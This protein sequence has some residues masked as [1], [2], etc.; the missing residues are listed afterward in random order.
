VRHI[1]VSMQAVLCMVCA[2]AFGVAAVADRFAPL[3]F[4]E[5]FTGSGTLMVPLAFTL[6][7]IGFANVIRTQWILPQSRDTVFVKSVSCG[8]AVNLIAN[9]LLIPQMGAMGAVI[10]TLLA[11]GTVPL[12][13]YIILRKELPYLRYLTDLAA[14]CLIGGAMM[15]CVRA[16]APVVPEGWLGLALQVAAGGCCYGVLCLLLWIATGNAALLRLIPVI[17][18]K[19]ARRARR[20]EDTHAV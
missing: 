20:T 6:V 8:A 9:A 18:R 17:G 7:M 1:T 15:L 5:E 10:G 11:E 12:V 16:L 13:Q 4:G 3:F 2:M 19:L 14:Y